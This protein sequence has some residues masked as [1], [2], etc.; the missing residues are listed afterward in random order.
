MRLD[1]KRDPDGG[2]YDRYV[3]LVDE[4]GKVI[5]EFGKDPTLDELR[6]AERSHGERIN[7]WQQGLVCSD[8]GNQ[9]TD[10]FSADH[11]GHL[12]CWGCAT[13]HESDE[14]SGL[15]TNVDPTKSVLSQSKLHEKSLCDYVINVATGCRHGCKFCYVPSTPAIDSREDML[16]EQADVDDPQRDWGDYILYRDDLPERVHEGLQNTDFEEDWK[17][18]QRGRGVVMLSSGTDCYQDRRAAQITR[19]CVHELVDAHIPVRILSRSPNLTRDIDLFKE[20]DGLVT[21]G[22]SIPSFDASLVSALEPNAPPPMARWEALDE[23][24]RA[25]VPRFVSFSPTYPTMDRDEIREALSWFSAV[26]PEVV[27]H[28]PMNPRG[29]NFE[30]C[31]EATRDAGYA[32]V[33]DELERIHNQGEW[34]EYALDH[35]EMVREVAEEEFDRLHIHSWPDRKLIEAALGR[36]KKRLKGLKQEVSPESFSAAGRF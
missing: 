16:S 25:D 24:F 27:F 14:Q 8:C 17:Q 33:A 31:L 20:A 28:E 19:G 36:E 15:T 11:D 23:L 30:M 18:T 34:I 12:L 6:E 10:R 22:T 9:I 1:T 7:L 26:D 4:G 29:A 35:I 2:W 13:D 5:E 32:D 3:H 21:V